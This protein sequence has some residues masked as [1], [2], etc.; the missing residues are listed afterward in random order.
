MDSPGGIQA[1]TEGFFIHFFYIF[2][3]C[4]R[5]SSNERGS[6]RGDGFYGLRV[7]LTSFHFCRR[8]L[9][10]TVNMVYD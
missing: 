4:A 8:N 5:N 9:F 6:Q 7:R 3:Y 1:E 2:Y 10:L